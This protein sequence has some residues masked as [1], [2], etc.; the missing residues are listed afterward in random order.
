MSSTS[1]DKHYLTQNTKLIKLF[2]L[3]NLTKDY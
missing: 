1:Q 3:T 2:D